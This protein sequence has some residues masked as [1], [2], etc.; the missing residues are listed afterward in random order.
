VLA[1]WPNYE[2]ETRRLNKQMKRNTDK[3]SED[4]MFRLQ[5][6]VKKEFIKGKNNLMEVL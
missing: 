6:N 1:F 3:S 4:F 5:I 2:A